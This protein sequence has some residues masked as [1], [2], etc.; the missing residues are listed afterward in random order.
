MQFSFGT[1]ASKAL[2]TDLLVVVS[3]TSTDWKEAL[4]HRLDA[5]TIKS[6]GAVA[7][8]REFA[9]KAGQ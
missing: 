6:L 1:A 5:D 3:G 2:K 8:R 9:G 7:K 4:T